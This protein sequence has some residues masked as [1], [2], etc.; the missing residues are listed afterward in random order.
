MVRM[1]TR[2]NT[3]ETVRFPELLY[4][5]IPFGSLLDGKI[6]VT[7]RVGKLDFEA[8]LSQF[9]SKRN[10]LENGTLSYVEFDI[11]EYKEVCK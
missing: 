10:I 7:D 6:I 3:E 2:H 9:M 11:I 5:D 8:M 4:I 1:Y